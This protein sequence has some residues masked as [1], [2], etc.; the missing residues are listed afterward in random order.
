MKYF[1]TLILLVSLV[2]IISP[3]K[4]FGSDDTSRAKIQKHRMTITQTLKKYTDKWMT[5][6]GVTGTGEGQSD[7]K[8]CIM[9]FTNGNEAFI[10]TKI[11]NTVNGYKV[12]FHETGEIHAH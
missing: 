1:L 12:I 9:I 4:S 5:I 6:P 3:K 11:P 10:K 2:G 8:P 7:H